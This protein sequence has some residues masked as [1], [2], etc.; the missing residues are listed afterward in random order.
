L[1]LKA[2]N[3][4]AVIWDW[5]GTLL[6]DVDICIKCINTLLKKRGIPIINREKY[7]EIFTFPVKDY[8]E[9]AGFDFSKEDFE[10]PAMEFIDL[11]LKELPN[12]KLFA[13]AV[14][15]LN[16]FK[17]QGINQYV[18]SA[19]EHKSLVKSLNDYGI[20]DYFI[21]INGMDNIY[22]HSKLDIG[23]NMLTNIEIEKENLILIGDTLHDKDV[24]HGL[25]INHL[26]IANGHQSKNRLFSQTNKVI[27][28]LEE[29]FSMIDF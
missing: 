8:Y 10:I 9:K 28:N 22:A 3:I 11:Y 27:N 14:E 2:Q 15:V 25:G 19:M 20:Y 29:L 7:I 12:S 18:L 1:Q 13:A 24:A 21:D 5:N 4:E 6:N 17:K 23:K 16:S 26:I